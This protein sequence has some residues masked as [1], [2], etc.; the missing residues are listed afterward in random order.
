MS[1]AEL[2]AEEHRLVEKFQAKARALRAADRKLSHAAAL[3]LAIQSLPNAAR[4]YQ[5][6]LWAMQAAGLRQTPL[7]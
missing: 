3:A 1:N 7:E 6:T 5:E 2:Y 4:R